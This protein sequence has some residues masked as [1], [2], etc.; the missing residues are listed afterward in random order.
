MARISRKSEGGSSRTSSWIVRPVLCSSQL[1]VEHT[2]LE[3]T[4]GARALNLGTLGQRR[5]IRLDV[6]CIPPELWRE[7]AS[8]RS[9]RAR[10]TRSLWNIALWIGSV[11][12]E[13]QAR[14]WLVQ[15]KGAKMELL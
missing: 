1:Q 11:L 8:R 12:N 14:T 4:A 13:N 6:L 5:G 3:I 9:G 7:R 2:L 10:P 15:S